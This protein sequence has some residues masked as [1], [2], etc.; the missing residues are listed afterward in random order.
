MSEIWGEM[1]NYF[2]NKTQQLKN[3]SKSFKIANIVNSI[4]D[5]FSQ[6]KKNK[7]GV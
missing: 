6:S 3:A 2:G 7:V 1:R 4:K 5:K